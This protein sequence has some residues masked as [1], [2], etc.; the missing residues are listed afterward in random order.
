[1]E[2]IKLRKIL[3]NSLWQILEKIIT[4]II[5]VVVTGVV[6][7]Y[8]GT[9][10]YGTVNYIISIVM[11]FTTFST[12][13]LETI[14]IKD[15]TVSEEKKETIIG[16]GIT[17]RFV[18]GLVLIVLSQLVIGILSNWNHELQILGIIM[19]SSMLFKSFE[20]I[21][22]YIQSIMKLKITAIIRFITTIIVS[23]F[24]IIV[25]FMDW[26]KIGFIFSY[27]VDTSVAAL[28]LYCWYRKRNSERFKISK[29]Y[30]KSILKRCWYLAI[31]GLMTTIYMRMDQV[32]L[33]SMMT[34]QTE[35]GIYSAAVRI[36][37]MWYFV[38]MA[39]IAA[40]QP[41][42]M[43][44]K[45]NNQEKF[46]EKQQELYDIV[47]IIGFVCIIG[48]SIFGKLAIR[49]LYGEEYLGA[50][51]I[52]LISIWSGLFAT[53]GCARGP[54]LISEGLQKYTIIYI[55]SGA[56]VNTTFNFLLIPNFGGSGAAIATLIAQMFTSI[57]TVLFIPKMRIS[58]VMML[59]SI[60]KNK[61]I[62]KIL[63]NSTKI[64][65]KR[66]EKN[67]IKE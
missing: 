27:L 28:L 25:V 8:L 44:Y 62:V 7:R 51:P 13:G 42:I 56:I 35:N 41:I 31:S 45:K 33:G 36:A 67:E 2:D 21:E 57:I 22:Y 52:L 65:K 17:I 54:W 58:G 60:F 4:M 32:M 47:S 3:G 5:V 26:G 16:T 15:L 20:V 38:P 50:A 6:A 55:T 39:V 53:L 10:D 9:E 46:I 49:I 61:T 63:K 12:L 40:F 19:G 23:I 59:K 64:I 18:G 30:A 66:N 14:S 43:K 37:E 48:I 29:K 1:M 11:L 24:K 34:S